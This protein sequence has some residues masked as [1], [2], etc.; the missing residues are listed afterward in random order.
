MAFVITKLVN[1]T[2]LCYLYA[3][4]NY[5]HRGEVDLMIAGGIEAVVIPF[6]LDGFVSYRTYLREMMILKLLR[7]YGMKIG[8]VLSWMKVLRYR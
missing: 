8:I 2:C 5:I 3:A 7:G 1:F 6:G 4:A